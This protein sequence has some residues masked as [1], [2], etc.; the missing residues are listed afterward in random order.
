MRYYFLKGKKNGC[1]DKKEIKRLIFSCFILVLICGILMCIPTS[2]DAELYDNVIRFHVIANSDTEQDQSLKL[3]VRDAVIDRYSEYLSG[4]SAKEAAQ[5][6]LQTLTQEIEEFANAVIS[7]HGY[8]YRCKVTLGEEY[9]QRTV[10]ENFSMPKGRY[11]SLRIIIGEGKGHNW[12]C[13]L[14]PPLCTKAAL[15]NSDISDS[16]DEFI[17]VGFTGEQYNIITK[18]DRPRYRVKFK[19]LEI[20]FGS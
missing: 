13:V 10:Y 7:E 6:G 14:F 16:E 8:N 3:S 11:T 12:W 17:N 2:A 18:T 4:Y 20:L 15:K 5:A 9:Y 1:S 19:L